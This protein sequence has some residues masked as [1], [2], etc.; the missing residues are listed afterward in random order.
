MR[1]VYLIIIICYLF[2]I[3]N[4]WL[5]PNYIFPSLLRSERRRK[6]AMLE[7]LLRRMISSNPFQ[8]GCKYVYIYE[9]IAY[10]IFIIL[11]YLRCYHRQHLSKTHKSKK[12]HDLLFAYC[13]IKPGNLSPSSIH[14][15]PFTYT[16]PHILSILLGLHLVLKEPPKP[17]FIKRPFDTV[18][19]LIHPPFVHRWLLLILF[20]NRMLLWIYL[21]R[22]S[23]PILFLLVI[24]RQM[25]RPSR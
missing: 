9:C 21:D 23:L 22:I 5:F 19:V 6:T 25:N 20:S 3:L 16:P 2:G 12:I 7:R 15:P 8:F 13:L 24:P 1:Q 17:G 11:Y 14:P 4:N 10:L 18:P